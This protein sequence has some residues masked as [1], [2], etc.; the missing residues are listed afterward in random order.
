MPGN[1]FSAQKEI[2]LAESNCCAPIGQAVAHFHQKFA[3]MARGRAIG[4]DFARVGGTFSSEW[5]TDEMQIMRGNSRM[6]CLHVCLVQLNPMRPGQ[7]HWPKQAVIL[8][9]FSLRRIFAQ[10]LVIAELTN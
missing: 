7:L 9:V 1:A 10:Q 4:D 5:A 8:E 6:D 2:W 3:Q